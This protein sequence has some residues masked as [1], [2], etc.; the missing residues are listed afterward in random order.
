MK[1]VPVETEAVHTDPAVLTV[2]ELGFAWPETVLAGSVSAG[3][4]SSGSVSAGTGLS[5][6]GS[7]RTDVGNTAGERLIFGGLSFT[8]EPGQ[9]IGV[10]GAVAC[11]KSTLG[12]AFLCEH[13]YM[14]SIRFAGKELAELPEETR[15]GIVG[16]MGH[17]PELLSD[18]IRNNVLLGN[19]G[20]A[21]EYLR[22]V[23][24]DG[25]VAEMPDGENTRVGSG[26]VRLSG[27]QQARLALARTLAHKKPLLVLDD[28]F[29]ALD[30]RTEREVFAN[31]K[32][33]AGDS[34][35]ILISHRLYLF[36]EMDQVIWMEG[37]RTIT[38]THGELL[39]RKPQYANLYLTQC[40]GGETD[41]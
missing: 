16:F 19:A 20:D 31:L 4:G 9:I 30:R 35:I 10:T 32:K 33:L 25:E 40:E 24:L 18:S 14:G 3:A 22:A 13:P 34:I 39:Q 27:G 28:P 26:G 17:E 41:V 23:C 7:T 1:P 37:G 38:G 36:P 6:T 8:A 29:S 11:G 2:E 21:A 5:G 12:K 15:C